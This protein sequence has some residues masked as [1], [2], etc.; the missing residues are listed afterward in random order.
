M[1]PRYAFYLLFIASGFAGLIYESVWTHYLKLYLGHAAYAQSLVLIVFMGGM[2]LGA[3]LCARVSTRI[4]NPLAAYAAIEGVIG[5]CALVFHE[6]FVAATDWSYASL[7]PALGTYWPAQSA[8]WIALAAK[9]TVACVLILPQSVLLGATFPL[10][11]AGLVRT[12]NAGTRPVLGEPVAML[13]FANSLGAA[14]GVLASGFTSRRPTSSSGCWR[15][16]RTT[17]WRPAGLCRSC[18]ISPAR[19]NPSSSSPATPTPI[20]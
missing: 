15:G 17:C 7:L 11:S 2:A 3:A 6:I 13:Y 10:M 4:R 1:A 5:V 14:A 8:G 18:G 19:P 16:W 20:R 9:L 12:T